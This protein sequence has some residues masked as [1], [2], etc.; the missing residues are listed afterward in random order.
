[1]REGGPNRVRPF[2]FCGP[3]NPVDHVSLS[4]GVHLGA[5]EIVALV[6]AGGMGEVYRARDTRLDRTVAIK[7]LPAALAADPLLRERFEREA[8]TISS[9]NHPHI[10]ALYDIGHHAGVDFLV[11][12]YLEGET[13]AD[14]LGRSKDRPLPLPDVLK[15]A[16]EVCDALDRAHRS[17]IVHRDL[18][19]ANVFLVRAG[20]ASAPPVAK[21]LDFGLAKSAAPVVATTGL[22]MLPTTPPNLTAQGTILGTF[23]YMAPEQIEGLEADARTDIFAFGALLF[24]MLAG[25]P[26]FEGKTRASL[27]GAILKDEPPRVSTLHPP[28]P[29]ALDR[30]VSTCLAKDPDERYQSARDLLRDLKW[31]ASG[32]S[33]GATARMA[34]PPARSNRVAWLV[35]ALSTVALIATA[36]IALRREVT[37]AAGPV[38]FTIAPPEKMFFGGPRSGGTGT[39]TQLAVSPDGRNIVFVAGAEPA[40]QIWLRP[41]AARA[42][43]VIP[44]TEGGTFPFWSPDSRSIGFFAGGKLKKVQIAGGPPIAL[45]DA[46]SGRGGS[47]SRDNVI[48]FAPSLSNGTG[49]SRVSSAGGAPAV[50]TTVDPGTTETNHRWP[51]FLPDGRHFFYTASTGACCPASQP[52]TIRIGSLDPA[53]ATITLLQAE[54]SMSYASGHVLFARDGMLMAQA[55]D[56]DARQL[57]GDAVPIGERVAT[58]G[59]RYIS[60]SVS[61]NG[62]LVYAGGSSPEAQRLTWFDR[63]GRVLATL[64]EAPYI[65]RARGGRWVALSRDEKRV[66]ITLETG[67]SLNQDIWIIDVARNLRSRLTVG[68]EAEWSPV[69]SPDG[70]RIAFAGLRGE[71]G[72]V[73]QKLV[74][75]ASADEAVLDSQDTLIPSDWSADGRFMAYS[76]TKTFPVRSDVWVLPLF[77]DRKPFPVADTAFIETSA[78][79]SPDG[80]WIAFTSDEAGQP[81]VYVQPFLGRGGRQQVSRDGGGQAVWRADGKELFF[82]APEGTLM[83]APVEASGEFKAGP[84]ALFPAI[85][86]STLTLFASQ[87]VV[88]KDGQRF[89]VIA[90]PDQASAAPL[91]VVV[92]WPATVQK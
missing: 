23:Q 13:L 20:G 84:Q 4:P 24:E 72:S 38:Q 66:A 42:A 17:G 62:T 22:S 26:A 8:R 70:T 76:V 31:V 39:A 34:A 79:F 64:G 18:K 69:W 68:P 74:T 1:M 89:L 83:A 2:S 16:I 80:R 82:I 43:T 33:E 48:V 91:T 27:L 87:F 30:I 75:E 73:R 60:A 45:C 55:F 65:P 37:P 54:S 90:R 32:S 51:H 57:T 53:D 29:A 5:Y 44:G 78:V 52:A 25:R 3:Y 63:S 56:L 28:A 67:S 35:A 58:E 50:V 71:K 85:P 41:V 7:V 11:L 81:N 6:G 88:T 46:P 61:E 86:P 10:C 15:I 14:R 59:S 40:Y 19:P 9:L 49:L 77:G 92:N 36:V 12:E 21:L 47:W